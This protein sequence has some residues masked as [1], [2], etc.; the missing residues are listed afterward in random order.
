[1]ARR[2]DLASPNSTAQANRFGSIAGA[3]LLLVAMIVTAC[4]GGGGATTAPGQPAASSQPSDDLAAPSFDLPVG[5]TM[6]PSGAQVRVANLYRDGQGQ[7][8]AVDIYTGFTIGTGGAP[9][10]TVQYGTVSDWFDPLVMDDDGDAEISFLPPGQKDDDHSLG[11]QSETLKGGEK[12]T[13][14]LASGDNKNA[15][16]GQFASWRTT[17]ETDTTDFPLPTPAASGE[18]VVI[19][20]MLA[21]ENVPAFDGVNFYAKTDGA[22]LKSIGAD[23]FTGAQPLSG[24]TQSPFSIPASQ[25][26]LSI[27]QDEGDCTSAPKLEVPLQLAAGQRSFLAVYSADGKTLQ[28][29]TIPI[30]P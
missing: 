25:T 3:A 14:L 19:I 9:V 28:A 29:L 10:T 24:G 27:H 21:L 1:V 23:Q 30:A 16:G 22:C 17:F 5:P 2:T 6:R 4:S 26:S 8:T 11:N 13:I 7:G 12:I 15:S 20:D 18:A